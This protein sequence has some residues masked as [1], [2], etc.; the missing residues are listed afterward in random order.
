MAPFACVFFLL[1][2]FVLFNSGLVFTP[3]VS[4]KL[5]YAEGLPGLTNQAVV[6]AVAA[7]GICYYENQITPENELKTKLRSA[8]QANGGITLV[9][10][11]DEEVAYK[12]FLELGLIARDAGISNVLWAVRREL[13]PMEIPPSGALAP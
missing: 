7:N 11:A 9:L 3:G 8:V 4:L 12:K 6:V 2:I 5:P 1:L 13:K 10:Q